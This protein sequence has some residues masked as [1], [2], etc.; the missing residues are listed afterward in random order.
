[1][2]GGSAGVRVRPRLFVVVAVTAAVKGLDQSGG[3]GALGRRGWPRAGSGPG[4]C[5]GQSR[6]ART[7]TGRGWSAA[8]LRELRSPPGA[9]A[10]HPPIASSATG[11]DGRTPGRPS[12]TTGR[13]TV[14]GDNLLRVAG[15]ESIAHN[16][17]RLAGLGVSSAYPTTCSLRA[18]GRA[19]FRTSACSLRRHSM[20][21][22]AG[23]PTTG[24]SA[25]FGQLRRAGHRLEPRRENLDAQLQ[26]LPSSGRRVSG[27]AR[28]RP[29]PGLRRGHARR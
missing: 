28:C 17:L 5:V 4:S 18:P 27:L 16:L 11:L 24:R 26:P 7:G 1:M 22:S 14:V 19:V 15:K 6:S 10:S 20:R 13:R 9:N 29:L 25:A 23:H 12:R 21:A 3:S 8:R 2:F